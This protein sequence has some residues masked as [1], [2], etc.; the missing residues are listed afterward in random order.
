[1]KRKRKPTG[2]I[3]KLNIDK[4]PQPSGQAHDF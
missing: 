2:K 4:R 1:M 3:K